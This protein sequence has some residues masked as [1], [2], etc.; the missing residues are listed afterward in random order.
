MSEKIKKENENKSLKVM[1]INLGKYIKA[2]V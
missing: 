1:K 2:E